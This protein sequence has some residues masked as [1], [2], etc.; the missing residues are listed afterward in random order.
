MESEGTD[1]VERGGVKQDE[2]NHDVVGGGVVDDDGTARTIL[3]GHFELSLFLSEYG[4]FPNFSLS[5][6]FLCCTFTLSC[7]SLSVVAVVFMAFSTNHSSIQ[8]EP[9]YDT[10]TCSVGLPPPVRQDGGYSW[11]RC[12]RPVRVRNHVVRNETSDVQAGI[13][14]VNSTIHLE[15]ETDKRRRNAHIS[16]GLSLGAESIE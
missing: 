3:N 11:S 13:L 10:C 8:Y 12:L 6:S 15:R 2:K 16:F 4:H 9:Q 7:Y 1:I 14:E 5:N